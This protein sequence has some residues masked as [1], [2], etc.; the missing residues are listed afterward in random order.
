VPFIVLLL[1]CAGCLS[2]PALKRQTFALESPAPATA[3]ETKGEGVLAIRSFEISP[4][5]AGQAFVYRIG[6]ESYERDPYAGFIVSA[7]RALEIPIR[8]WL[9][10]SGA[11]Q[12]IAEPG[13]LLP[14]DRQLEIYVSELYGD[15]RTPSKPVAVLSM[16]FV[17]FPSGKSREPTAYR[18]RNYS[19]RLDVPENTAASIVAG[20]NKALAEIMGQAA[21]DLAVAR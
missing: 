2:R 1:L 7:D 9:R 8:A 16:R 10:H 21:S 14:A 18:E 13:S 11:F 19:R 17:F 12:D 20:W 6:A 4:L 5:F 15:L 3:P